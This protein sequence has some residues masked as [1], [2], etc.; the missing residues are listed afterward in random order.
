MAE[1]LSNPYSKGLERERL[2]KTNFRDVRP[3]PSV[4]E[5]GRSKVS[6]KRD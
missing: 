4:V 5:C 6:S 2:A 1:N 3:L